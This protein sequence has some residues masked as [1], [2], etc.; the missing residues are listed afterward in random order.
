MGAGGR[1][2]ILVTGAAGPAGRALGA[3]LVGRDPE[4]RAVGADLNPVPVT[5]FDTVEAVPAAG[6]PRYE[7]AM[8]D[9]IERVGPDLVVPTVSEEL[10]RIA[11][12]GRAAGLGSALVGS[13]ASAAAVAGDKLL[14]MWTLAR[15]GVAVPAFA[16]ADVFASPAVALEW[17]GGPVVVKPR[18]A[19]GGRGVHVV[20]RPDDPVWDQLDAAWVVQVFAPA[21]E[22]SPQVY[23]S[24]RTGRTVVVVLQK[25]ALEHG[26]IGNATAVERLPDGSAPDV[27]ALALR[28]VQALDL[29]GPVDMDVRRLA[30]GAPVVLEVNARF[31]AVSASAPQILDAVLDDW[32]G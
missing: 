15:A 29:V 3:Q 20:D 28:T 10:P 30:D 31:G 18:V 6:D 27:A 12:F 23:R 13:S 11:V 9:L 4:L 32:P 16:P 19:R 17:A 2:T 1:R 7:P 8:R 25:A 24:P 22:Y 21:V 5:G 26:R 14:T